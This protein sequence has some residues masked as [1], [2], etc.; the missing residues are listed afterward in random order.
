MA[1]HEKAGL[2]RSQIR[3][4]LP[5]V[6]QSLS[7]CSLL[8]GPPNHI[9]LTWCLMKCNSRDN[10]SFY[11]RRICAE[12]ET[13]VVVLKSAVKYNDLPQVSLIG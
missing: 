9:Y 11:S 4:P 8:T 10:I 5:L 13:E 3:G 6:H 2:S 1:W 12:V 7:W